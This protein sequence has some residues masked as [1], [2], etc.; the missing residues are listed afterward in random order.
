MTAM[1]AFLLGDVLRMDED[2]PAGQ[3]VVK[4]FEWKELKGR[5]GNFCSIVSVLSEDYKKAFYKGIKTKSEHEAVA[6]VAQDR[7]QWKAVFAKVTDNFCELRVEKIIK[8]RKARKAKEALQR[9]SNSVDS[10][11]FV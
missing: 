2:V 6:T 5:Q 1:E 3:T 4:Y 7:V 9:K 11:L 10:G 8:R